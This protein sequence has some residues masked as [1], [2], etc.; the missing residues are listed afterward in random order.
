MSG[1]KPEHIAEVNYADCFDT[2]VARPGA[3]NAVFVALKPG[4]G[5]DPG[6]GSYVVE[7]P[8]T[9]PRAVASYHNRLVGIYDAASGEPLADVAV[10]D[11]STG[12]FATT[13]STGTASLAFLPDGRTVLHITRLGY[14]FARLDVSISPRDTTPIT[15]LLDRAK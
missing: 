5:Y 4:I 14:L 11:S 1:I 12:T 13:S 9:T 15:L 3:Q 2:S 6:R 7:E 8:E 10:K